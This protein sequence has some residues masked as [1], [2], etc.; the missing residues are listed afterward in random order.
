MEAQYWASSSNLWRKDGFKTRAAK[1]ESEK[2]WS[3]HRPAEHWSRDRCWCSWIEKKSTLRI[4]SSILR[5][6]WCCWCWWRWQC[7]LRCRSSCSLRSL[8]GSWTHLSPDCC[9]LSW[10][11]S[12]SLTGNWAC[13]GLAS[14]IISIFFYPACCPALPLNSRFFKDSYPISEKV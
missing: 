3:D 11:S 6:T 7:W 4:F 9:C 10:C 12:H 14:Q 13:Y 5:L 2:S 8:F 1:K